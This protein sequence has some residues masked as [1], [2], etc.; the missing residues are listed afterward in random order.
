MKIIIREQAKE[1]L[2]QSKYGSVEYISSATSS[3][4]KDIH[5]LLTDA[6]RYNLDKSSPIATKKSLVQLKNEV[7]YFINEYRE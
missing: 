5:R 2:N 6:F 7:T 4:L 3:E 1:V